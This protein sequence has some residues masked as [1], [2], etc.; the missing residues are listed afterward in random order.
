[1]TTRK[2]IIIFVLN[3][4]AIFLF[5]CKTEE[6]IVHGDIKGL[7]TD[8]ETSEPIQSA[9]IRL[10]PSNDTTSTVNDGAYLLKNLVPGDYEIQASKFSYGISSKN[11]EV[12]AAK[13]KEINFT[14]NGIP[15]PGF[16]DTLLDFGLDSTT[17]SFTISNIG[18]GKLIYNIIP[19]QDWI[20]VIPASG[21]ITEE[22]DS[23][24]VM[25]DKTGLSGNVYKETIRIASVVGPDI[26]QYP[27]SVYLNGLMDMN[28][29][30]YKVVKI[31]SQ[32]WM[33]ENLNFGT[34][35]GCYL[36]DYNQ[37]DN[38]TIEKYCIEEYDHM[39]PVWGGLYDWGEMM[40]YNPSD[41]GTTGTTQGICPVFWHI[42]TSKE[43]ITLIDYLGG[44]EVA[45]GKLKD[46]TIVS[47][48]KGGW[49]APNPASNESGF[50][51]I[52]G[53]K[54]DRINWA[55]IGYY[56]TKDYPYYGYWWSSTENS[57]N[58]GFAYYYGLNYLNT[59]LSQNDFYDKEI[60]LS[61]RC[62]KD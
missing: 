46:T 29:N 39:C 40:Q 13:T 6:V 19:S 56:Y 16:S 23:I 42:P 47:I 57:L 54:W 31:G 37:T 8:A 33:A 44:P 26:I 12:V 22:T 27:I 48:S 62:V 11:I 58:P 21:D 2:Y 61:V 34:R 14:L 25:I 43:W 59:S 17:L 24:T 3:I 55:G 35:I 5:S 51:G 1:M 45:G 38:G 30:Y 50:T 49:R 9:K 20:T 28:G 32:T 41:D 10:N 52:G 60:G 4:I 18:K 36:C 53:G 15:L 7:V